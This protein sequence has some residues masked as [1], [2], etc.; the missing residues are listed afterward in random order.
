M[1]EHTGL[2]AVDASESIRTGALAVVRV[3]LGILAASEGR[4][5][6][7]EAAA[8]ARLAKNNEPKKVRGEAHHGGQS[9]GRSP[10]R[11]SWARIASTS[12]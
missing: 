9:W 3:A 2:Y 12:G 10:I 5:K 7:V 6:A 1:G 4:K 8:R 11:A